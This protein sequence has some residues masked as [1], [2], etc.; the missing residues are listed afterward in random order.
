M[1]TE[2]LILIAGYL[3]N[4]ERNTLIEIEMH[5]NSRERF[6]QWYADVTNNF[7][8][9]E[10]TDTTPYYIWPEDANK[11]GRQSRVYFSSNQNIPQVLS[12]ILEPREINTRHGYEQFDKRFNGNDIIDKLFEL[13]FVIGRQD[14]N[15]IR[16]FIP[17]DYLE[18]FERGFNL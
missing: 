15:R 17:E 11:W 14:T 13:G 1:N 8:L 4:I 6:E 9:P 2:D 10:R 7:P 18:I 16:R 12:S 5:P 3:A